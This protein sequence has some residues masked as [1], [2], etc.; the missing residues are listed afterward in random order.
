MWEEQEEQGEG[1]GAGGGQD[2]VK[3]LWNHGNV[4]VGPVITQ[5]L[6]RH[7]GGCVCRTLFYHDVYARARGKQ[8]PLLTRTRSIFRSIFIYSMSREIPMRF[9]HVHAPFHCDRA[10]KDEPLQS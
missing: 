3:S 5:K 6:Q 2:P 9:V 8:S 1:G 7:L 10:L 4:C